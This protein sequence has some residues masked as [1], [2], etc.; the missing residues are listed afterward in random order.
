MSPRLYNILYIR[1]KY[2]TR[3]SMHIETS[4]LCYNI[5]ISNKDAGNEMSVQFI[6]WLI[7]TFKFFFK[8]LFNNSKIIKTLFFFF[9]H[10]KRK[11]S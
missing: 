4:D 9:H 11:A 8:S 10:S 7:L 5:I 2:I 6:L 1:F 3:I